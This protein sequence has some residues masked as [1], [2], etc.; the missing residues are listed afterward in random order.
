[1]SDRVTIGDMF[2]DEFRDVVGLA[3][4]IPRGSVAIAPSSILW[5]I[6]AGLGAGFIVSA[7][8][9]IAASLLFSASRTTELQ[10]PTAPE[11]ATVAATA[12]ALAVAWRAGGWLAA[13]GY[14]A[15]IAAEHLLGIPRIVRTC[16]D[17]RFT[18]SPFVADTCTLGGQL[19]RL[20][21]LA[22]GCLLALV[23]VRAFSRSGA[24]T[25]G[26][27]E[28]AGALIFAQG[29]WSPIGD[30]V[31]SQQSTA[32]SAPTD[33]TAF[34]A[35]GISQALIGGVAAGLVL[36]RRGRWPWRGFAAI[37]A[38]VLL[39]YVWFSLRSLL[40][41][42]SQGVGPDQLN[43]IVGMLGF[44]SPLFML[45]AAA[46]ALAISRSRVFPAQA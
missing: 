31:L 28:A 14:L 42:L 9:R 22:L 24:S 41:S 46:G 21:P 7:P 33:A 2:R 12:C 25:N 27:L 10:P 4:R 29:L 6:L 19:L 16:A 1:V 32:A 15:F 23:V 5:A 13:E 43:G 38:V 20:W 34:A 17:P 30:L 26:A 37:A 3:A 35:F 40:Y 18:G 36:A 8:V 11:L 45:A 39:E 44:G